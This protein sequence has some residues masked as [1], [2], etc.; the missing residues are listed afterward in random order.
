MKR[1]Y[2]IPILVGL[3]V[4]NITLLYYLSGINVKFEKCSKLVYDLSN[5]M[6]VLSNFHL[7]FQNAIM[8]NEGLKISPNFILEKENSECVKLSELLSDEPTLIFRYSDLN[9]NTCVEA[10]FKNI[11]QYLDKTNS[12]RLV[13]LADYKNEDDLF[14]FKRLNQVEMPI[15][16]SKNNKLNLPVEGLNTPYFFIIDSTLVVRSLFIPNKA[17][18]E[19]SKNYYTNIFSPKKE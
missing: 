13:I 17:Y 16:N 1:S 9:C 15:Y 19:F 8:K 5:E 12:N 18:P 6:K 4:I 2:Y 3:L 11:N 10:E 14:R 7:I